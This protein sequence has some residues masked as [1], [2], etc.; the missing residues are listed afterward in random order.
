M[1]KYVLSKIEMLL[2]LCYRDLVFIITPLSLA[3]WKAHKWI[4]Q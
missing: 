4:D 2:L 3:D 1:N